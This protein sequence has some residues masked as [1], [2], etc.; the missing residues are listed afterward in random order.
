MRRGGRPAVTEDGMR[1]LALVDSPDHVCCRYR[2]RAFEPAL[3]RAGWSLSCQELQRTTIPRLAQLLAAS[4]YDSVILQRK[5]LPAW[6]LAI[7]RRSAGHLVFDF[8]DAVLFRDSYS[9]RG[10]YSNMRQKRFAA[11][12]QVADTVIAGNDF[13]ADCA[14]RAGAP[15]S[16]VRM[17]PTCVEPTLYPDA[18]LLQ[19]E[20]V[21]S[22]RCDLVWIGSSSTLQGLEQQQPLWDRLGREIPGLR[23]RVICDR[24]PDFRNLRVVPVPWSQAWEARDLAAGRIG[25]SWLPED[26]WSQGKC[27]LKVLQYQAARLPVVA[28]PVGMH[29]EFVE[30]GVTGFLPR[31][32]DEW[33]DAIHTLAADEKLRSRMGRTARQR[34]EAGYSVGAWAETFVASVTAV[35]LPCF[36]ETTPSRRLAHSSIPAPFY[37]RLRRMGGFER[38][39]IRGRLGDNRE[40][41]DPAS[42]DHSR[43]CS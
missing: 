42:S 21:D 2:I 35:E 8:D 34:V 30:P 4:S 13:L 40:Y 43:I 15:A 3:K 38:A 16:R 25:I 9:R 31:T 32:T 26:P 41:D 19:A 36:G 24:F 23:M 5:L 6:Q 29:A 18:A 27:G 14:L 7:L 39:A 17:I 37:V 22:G 10:S 33:V 12:V 1:L 20:H 28:N 11:V